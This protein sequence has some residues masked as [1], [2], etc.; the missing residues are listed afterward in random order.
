MYSFYQALES[1]RAFM[2]A[3]GDV[4]WLIAI[5]TFFMWA[6]AFERIMFFRSGLRQEAAHA[7]ND[8]L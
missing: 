7:L 4:L 6:L 3:G 5:L 2:G 1:I 8:T